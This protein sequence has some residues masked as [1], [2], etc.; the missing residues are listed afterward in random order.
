MFPITAE[1]R[2]TILLAGSFIMV[3]LILFI[4][5]LPAMAQ[6]PVGNPTDAVNKQNADWKSYK[7]TVSGIALQ[8]PS[9]WIMYP[10]SY[11]DSSWHFYEI[12]IQQ[13]SDAQDY[14]GITVLIEKNSQKLGVDAFVRQEVSRLTDEADESKIATENVLVGGIPAVRVSRSFGAVVNSTYVSRGPFVYRFS[15][16]GSCCGADGKSDMAVILDKVLATVQFEDAATDFMVAPGEKDGS[17]PQVQ[18]LRESTTAAATVFTYPVAGSRSAGYDYG[19]RP[20]K[21]GIPPCYT[22]TPWRSLYHDGEDW[23]GASGTEVRAVADGTV[24]WYDAT[25]DYPGRVVIIK[26]TLPDGSTIYSMYG[27]LTSVSV[28]QGRSVAKEVKIGTMINRPLGVA[29]VD[30]GRG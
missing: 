5:P 27:H 11:I 13:P 14:S 9:S 4:S 17:L 2:L 1:R 18:P 15:L 19:E 16:V 23:M 28:A 24:E 20:N 25:Y 12:R 6:G 30:P 21:D 26:H 29:P 7:D 8:Y 3:M 10:G 22:P